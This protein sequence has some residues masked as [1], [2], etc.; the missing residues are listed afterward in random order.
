M[1]KVILEGVIKGKGIELDQVPPLP[2]GARV[3]VS[4][5]PR[6]LTVS[7]RQA[8]L[9]A[10]AGSCADDPSFSAAVHEAVAR[11]ELDTPRPVNLDSAS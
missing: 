7:E 4:L 2:D 10:L 5:E 9:T 11:R 6:T 3:T 8:L 1:G